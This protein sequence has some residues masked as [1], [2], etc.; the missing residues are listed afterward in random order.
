VAYG[1]FK[2]KEGKNQLAHT[3]NGSLLGEEFWMEF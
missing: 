2:A 1:Y 3:L